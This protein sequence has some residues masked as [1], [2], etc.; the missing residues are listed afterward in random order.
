MF[1]SSGRLQYQFGIRGKANGEIWY[2]AGVCVDNSG[3]IYVAD[4]GN[5][6]I[7][8]RYTLLM[9]MK[10]LVKWAFPFDVTLYLLRSI[11]ALFFLFIVV[12]MIGTL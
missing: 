8:V 2:P 5:H 3:L 10:Y 6:R 12:L 1:D 11:F 7:Q 9:N 4:H